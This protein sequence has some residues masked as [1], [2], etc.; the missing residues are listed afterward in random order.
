MLIVSLV[1]YVL[2]VSFRDG[3]FHRRVDVDVVQCG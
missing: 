3:S 2:L 1:L